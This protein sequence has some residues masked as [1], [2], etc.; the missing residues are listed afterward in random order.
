M[1]STLNVNC[2]ISD[3]EAA[4]GGAPKTFEKE[5]KVLKAGW[6]AKKAEARGLTGGHAW[7]NRWFLLEVESDAGADEGTVVKTAML[8]YYH[9]TADA[10]KPGKGEKIPL[11]E[12]MGV[13]GAVSKTKGT[14]HRV[15]VKTARREWELGS[16][17]E[18]TAAEW[19]SL[20]QQWIGLPKV[21]PRDICYSCYTSSG[22]DCPR[23]R[24]VTFVT[25]VILAVDRTAQ[26]GERGYSRYICYLRWSDSS[27]RARLQPVH[28]LPQVERQIGRAHV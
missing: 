2:I 8:T 6:L 24:P 10:E 17:E 22:S 23:W 26:G 14:E 18:A 15:T 1:L 21:A 4:S 5:R 19:I 16:P 20:L 25:A 13:K 9:S 27:R 11:W 7:Q 12:A 3:A 28:R